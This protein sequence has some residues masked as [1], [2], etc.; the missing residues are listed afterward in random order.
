MPCHPRHSN[1]VSRWRSSGTLS[2]TCAFGVFFS[3]CAQHRQHSMGQHG[4]RDVPVP[5]LPVANLVVI[6]SAFA[7]GG[8]KAL[9][10]LPALSGHSDKRLQRIFPGGSVT[11]IVG[12]LGL[13]FDTAPH[14]KRPR[15]AILL[16]EPHQG[17]VIE[18]FAL[19]AET[20][21]KPPP[22][23]V[24]QTLRN[25]VY[26]M[27]RQIRLPQALI[28][29]HRQHIR[30]LPSLQE[31]AQFAI[32]AVHLVGGNPSRSGARIQCPPDHAPRQLRLGGK[33]H[34]LRNPGLP[35]AFSILSPL[36]RNVKL[37]VHQRRAFVRAIAKKYADLAV[38]DAPR[39]AAILTL[40]TRRMLTLLQ[41]T[42][43]ID[44]EYR[45][46]TVQFF[47]S[48]P[49]YPVAR[50]FCI[51]ARSVEK[52]LD[53]IRR[54]F[55]HPLG[56]LPAVL[57]LTA[58]QQALQIRKAPR[59]GFRTRKQLRDQPMRPQT[60]RA[61]IPP[62]VSPSPMPENHTAERIKSSILIYN[63]STKPSNEAEVAGLPVRVPMLDIHTVGAGGGSLARF[64]AGG[65]LRVGPES[66]GAD[67]GPICY[68]R[69]TRPTVTDANLL[70]GRLQA[71][72]FLGGE[73]TLD[74]ERT[75]ALTREWH[76]S[77][78]VEF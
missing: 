50:L 35:A 57:A 16:G 60:T 2:R 8:L 73:F 14:Q 37:P 38:L 44:D 53:R 71:D 41:K 48:I 36:L 3:A 61:S 54:R 10:D 55:A 18:P 45:L 12:V 11:E 75:Q 29:S 20:G 66:A 26:P 76:R 21:G 65:A 22:C 51:P 72:L 70:L 30:H 47:H 46:P 13:F 52:M 23:L 17:P 69:G 67:P 9:L 32:V 59:T 24:G 43:L 62:D 34:R 68:G 19:A 77:R 49:A 25:R 27:L 1:A 7:L 64:D 31:P 56:Q 40:H 5:T 28:R 63:C 15:P 74:F 58:A 33:L 42:R 6:Q 39:R 78:W 4:Q